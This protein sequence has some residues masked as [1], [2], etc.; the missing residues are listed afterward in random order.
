MNLLLWSV[1][2]RDL[3][4]HVISMLF[5]FTLFIADLGFIKIGTYIAYMRLLF[6]STLY[7]CTISMIR[8]NT[9][10]K[11]SQDIYRSDRCQLH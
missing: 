7:K 1:T 2:S 3:V 8:Y 5:Y 9:V 10:H 4:N 6:F 11:H